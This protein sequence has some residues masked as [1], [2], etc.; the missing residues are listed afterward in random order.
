MLR[1]MN[2]SIEQDQ[3]TEEQEKVAK[4]PLVYK[5]FRVHRPFSCTIFCFPSKKDY[6][7][8]IFFGLFSI[9]QKACPKQSKSVA[10]EPDIVRTV[11]K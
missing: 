2:E 9:Q 3:T 10:Q 5:L 7:N 11:L 6:Q 4:I 1:A 8:R